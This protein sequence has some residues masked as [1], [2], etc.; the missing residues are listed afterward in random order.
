MLVFG[1]KI[2]LVHLS[3]SSGKGISVLLLV[4][5]VIVVSVLVIIFLR[6]SS[7]LS[8]HLILCR[9]FLGSYGGDPDGPLTLLTVTVAKTHT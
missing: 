9:H 6:H 4:A 8:F 3:S 2:Y 1:R 7:I 5:L